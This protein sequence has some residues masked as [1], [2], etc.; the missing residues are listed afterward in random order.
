VDLRGY[1]DAQN[2]KKEFAEHNFIRIYGTNAS[3]LKFISAT[4][5][6]QIDHIRKFHT[7]L[8]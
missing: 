8:P 5:S 2:I 6:G 7:T 3:I 4:E 1:S